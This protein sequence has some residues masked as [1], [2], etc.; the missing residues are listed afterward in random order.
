[1]EGF[2]TFV[3]VSDA[4]ANL[5]SFMIACD[6]NPREWT[7]GISHDAAARLKAHGQSD[8]PYAKFISTASDDVARQ[9]EKW[10]KAN[11]PQ[12]K[13]DTGGGN[14]QNPPTQVYI[15]RVPRFANWKQ[16]LTKSKGG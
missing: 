2:K 11:W 12:M 9:V 15:Y 6:G 5:I 16:V 8:N 7:I 3:G 14:P 4:V 10:F 13:G 1:M